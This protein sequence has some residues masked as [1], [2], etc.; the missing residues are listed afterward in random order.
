VQLKAVK[1]S[2]QVT[3]PVDTAEQAEHTE[4]LRKYPEPQLKAT[5]A[6]EQVSQ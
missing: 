1:A 2:L 3:Q 5:E 6:D 4:P